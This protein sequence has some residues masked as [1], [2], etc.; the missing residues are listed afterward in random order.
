MSYTITGRSVYEMEKIAITREAY[1]H[2]LSICRQAMPHEACGVLAGTSASQGEPSIVTSILP[3]TNIHHEPTRS[4]SFH[5]GEW[6]ST[7]YDM[8]KNRQT[9]VGFFHSHPTSSAVPS[10]QDLLG[11][12]ASDRQ[13]SYWIISVGNTVQP[14]RLYELGFTPL[15]LMLT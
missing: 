12:P 10:K 5:P 6:I 13:I 15:A 3:I 2:L 14:Y 9:L 8:Q 4:F 7:Y 11:F 1:E